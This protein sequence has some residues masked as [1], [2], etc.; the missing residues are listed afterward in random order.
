MDRRKA[1]AVAGTLALTVTA[2]ATAMAANVG[3]L[4]SGSQNS[5][6]KLDAQNVAALT[7]S[8]PPPVT[9][10]PST[11]PPSTDPGVEYV[12]QYVT[13]PGAAAPAPA[14]APTYQAPAP[15]PDFSH[16]DMP[17]PTERPAPVTTA[18]R[19]PTPTAAP[20]T[21]AP[22]TTTTTRAPTTTTTIQHDPGE[23]RDD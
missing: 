15:I 12:D 20:T 3:L 10:P 7:D 2:A 5:V 11:E 1:L 6:G 17:E 19:A 22:T 23:P 21:V 13:D 18:P 9:D 4:R 8:L 16:V 14:P